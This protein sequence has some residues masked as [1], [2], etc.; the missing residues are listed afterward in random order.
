MRS[1]SLPLLVRTPETWVAQVLSEPLALLGD[2]AHL[3][4]KAAAN[5]LELVS[6]W[7]GS[8]CPEAWVSILAAV[9]RD[10]A[11]HLQAVSRLLAARGGCLPR[12]HRNQYASAL[13]GLVRR[14]QGAH[15][16]LDRLLVS[17]LIEARSC[18][19]FELLGRCAADGELAAFFHSLHSSELGHY[20]VFL[21]LAG[22]LVTAHEWQPRW[23]GML[24]AEADILAAQSAGPR[25]HSGVN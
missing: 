3:E 9:A 11:V 5:A 8:A 7:P 16:L 15:E 20:K 17:A 23:Q 24:V 12:V 19:R 21:H 6:R 22:M 2:H 4:R 25:M 14:G 10:E 18:E 13:H 1:D